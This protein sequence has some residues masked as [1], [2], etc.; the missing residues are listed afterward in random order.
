[1]LRFR[2]GQKVENFKNLI[3]GEGISDTLVNKFGK[4]GEGEQSRIADQQELNNA[5]ANLGNYK[6]G[7]GGFVGESINAGAFVASLGPVPL[8]TIY[9]DN[10]H[11]RAKR[12]TKSHSGIC[13]NASCGT[14][15]W[16]YCE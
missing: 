5:R 4:V 10:L 9:L 14:F 2:L 15:C 3:G 11:L 16:R 13:V 7:L 8:A 12:S 1:M 6:T